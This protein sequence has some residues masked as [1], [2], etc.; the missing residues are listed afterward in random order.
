V[1]QLSN[2]ETGGGLLCRLLGLLS[3]RHCPGLLLLGVL[4]GIVRAPH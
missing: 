2:V 3:Q 1:R 4:D